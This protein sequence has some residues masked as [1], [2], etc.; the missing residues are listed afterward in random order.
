[1]LQ[2]LVVG[3]LALAL[4]WAVYSIPMKLGARALDNRR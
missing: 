2:V 4:T 3:V 1:M